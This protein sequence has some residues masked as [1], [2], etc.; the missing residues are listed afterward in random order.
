MVK[1][2]IGFIFILFLVGCSKK[3][4]VTCNIDIN[5]TKENYHM[6]GVYNIYYDGNYVTKIIKQETYVSSDDAMIE[7]FN[8][9]KS[10]E[11]Y[12]LNDLYGG[13]TYK[14]KEND[15]SINL[16]VVIDMNSMNVKEM[17]KDNYIDKNYVVSNKLTLTGAKYIYESKGA[18][19]DI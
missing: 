10:L 6:N 11:Y 9:S 17:V 16:D 4:Y 7:Y 13:V 15:K 8:E 18:K 3:E 12:N 2:I 5:N 14:I 19:C 1:K